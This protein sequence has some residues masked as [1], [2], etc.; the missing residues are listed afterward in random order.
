MKSILTVINMITLVRLSRKNLYLEEKILK[1]PN[2][3]KQVFL[4]LFLDFIHKYSMAMMR[5]AISAQIGK[6][7][8]GFY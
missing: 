1:S 5:D 7:L 3:T 4:I 8:E 2:K 6:F